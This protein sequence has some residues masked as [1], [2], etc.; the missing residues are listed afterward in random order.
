MFCKGIGTWTRQEGRQEEAV[1]MFLTRDHCRGSGNGGSGLF[2][3]GEV[4]LMVESCLPGV[5][6]W[7]CKE[8]FLDQ[9]GRRG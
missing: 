4:M 3:A 7:I 1:M 6:Y 8:V 2:E 5:A 9:G